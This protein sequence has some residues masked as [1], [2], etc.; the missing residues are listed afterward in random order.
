[1]LS[2]QQIGEN[3]FEYCEEAEDYDDLPIYL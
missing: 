2:E 3:Q 1:M